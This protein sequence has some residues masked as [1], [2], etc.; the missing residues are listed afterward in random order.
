MTLESGGEKKQSLKTTSRIYHLFLHTT[1][2]LPPC[3]SNATVP[4]HRH[5]LSTTCSTKKPKA[6]ATY[7]RNYN[8]MH[9]PKQ[10]AKERLRRLNL[11]LRLLDKLSSL[12]ILRTILT[13]GSCTCSPTGLCF[14][15]SL[16]GWFHWGFTGWYWFM[17]RLLCWG[18]R[19]WFS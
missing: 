1:T 14:R 16:G 10:A 5:N 9:S 15:L 8:A 13:N 3:I 17:S 12:F 18:I 4:S 19:G 6:S 2:V 11:F 7:I